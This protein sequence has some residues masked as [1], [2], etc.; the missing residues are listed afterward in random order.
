MRKPLRPL[1]S[2]VLCTFNRAHVVARAIRSVQRQ[3]LGD[4]ELVIIDDGSTDGSGPLLAAAA[5]A[6]RRIR[7][8]RQRNRGLAAARNAGVRR[9]RGLYV[10]FLDSDDEYT[11]SHLAKGLH[12]I[13]THPG[14]D[15][16]LGVLTPVGPLRRHYV[17]DIEHPGRHI[18]VSRCHA[19]GT[20][21]VRRSCLTAADGFRRLPFSEDYD[22]ILRLQ[23][24]FTIARVP[25]RTYRYHVGGDDRLC[26]LF[27]RGGHAAIRTFRSKSAA[28]N[29]GGR[30]S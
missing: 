6:D 26:M 30:T 2:V 11:P 21:L 19:A 24:K 25:H 29:R 14:T 15:G 10:A 8:F 7:P 9:C 27:D 18:H 20:L 28:A 22:L 12:W 4:W 23:Q 3:T 17:P 16:V 13:D 5:R 1:V